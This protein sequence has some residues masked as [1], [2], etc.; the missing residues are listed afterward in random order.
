MSKAI[1]YIAFFFISLLKI[2]KIA[3][4]LSVKESEVKLKVTITYC[5]SFWK[6]TVTKSELIESIEIYENDLD[7]N[8]IEKRFKPLQNYCKLQK[9]YFRMIDKEYLHK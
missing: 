5:D 3:E 6:T 2:K 4:K 1:F 7:L 8:N 9:Q